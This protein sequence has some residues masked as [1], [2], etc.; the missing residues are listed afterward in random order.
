MF[1]APFDDGPKIPESVLDSGA[2]SPSTT[3]CSP[4]TNASAHPLPTN[5]PAPTSLPHSLPHSVH[6]SPHNLT[7]RHPHRQKA[8]SCSSH[9]TAQNGLNTPPLA[10][11]ATRH[12]R[13]V[14]VIIHMRLAGSGQHTHST[15]LLRVVT[16]CRLYSTP[17]LIAARLHFRL[18]PC[19]IP[20]PFDSYHCVSCGMLAQ[21]F[22]IIRGK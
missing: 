15:R 10:K 12:V 4:Q 1:W 18:C 19:R 8:T 9:Q 20:Q 6:P 17:I 16:P 22:L 3:P 11:L 7:G 21:P 13:Q 14:S 5:P 2:D